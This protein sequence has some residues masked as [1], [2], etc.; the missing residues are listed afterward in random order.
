MRSTYTRT[1]LFTLIALCA[2]ARG[3]DGRQAAGALDWRVFN[4]EA[5]GFS[6]RFPG[7]PQVSRL[8]MFKGPL[9]LTRHV[10]QLTA[11]GYEFELDYV[12]MPAGYNE[13]ELA[14]E[15]GIIGITRSFEGEG[16]R[17][18]SRGKV[19][20]G[21]CEGLEA[22]FALAPR[23]GQAGYALARVFNSGQRYYFLVFISRGGGD[24]ARAAAGTFADSL[25]IKDGCKAPLIPTAAPT[26]PPVRSVVEGTRDPATGW[27]RIESPEHGFS[28]LMPGPAQRESAQSQ[29]QP[30][31][32]FHHEYVYES[33]EAI[34]AAE[35]VGDYP[36]GFYS[37]PAS[38][39]NLL[40]VTLAAIKRNLAEL[41]LAFGEPRKLNVGSYPGREYTL[42]NEKA[43]MRGR[44]QTYS[45]PRRAYIFVALTRGP[46]QRDKDVERFFSSV[47]VSPK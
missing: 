10:H 21:T 38:Y 47:R 22:T 24:A 42:A 12:D 32:L 46:T 23:A 20:R 34:Y 44:I 6:V 11:G 7:A 19:V 17:A 4:S 30:F 1:L 35:V 39:E 8:P 14:L 41:E 29:V 28:L 37:S 27:R 13:P 36:V 3:A 2:A 9:T 25:D 5:G 43:G 15:G 45:T 16:G 18:L 40:D 31:T 26:T 33:D